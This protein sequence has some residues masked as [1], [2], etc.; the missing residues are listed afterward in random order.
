M[1]AETSL[2]LHQ[3]ASFWQTLKEKAT[4]QQLICSGSLCSLWKGT[5]GQELA[6]THP[7]EAVSTYISEVSAWTKCPWEA[8]TPHSTLHTKVTAQSPHQL[9][10]IG[11]QTPSTLVW[12]TPLPQNLEFRWQSN[13]GG[14]GV[15]SH[16]ALL[17][18][19]IA[20]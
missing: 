6:P 15:I 16:P 20:G 17:L 11:N 5:P 10:N 2:A 8:E 1:L 3:A 12:V 9:A 7:C 19:V 14:A 13:G 4:A 18:Y